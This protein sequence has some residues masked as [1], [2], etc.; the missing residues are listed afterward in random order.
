MNVTIKKLQPTKKE[1]SDFFQFKLDLYKNNRYN[2]PDL[3]ADEALTLNPKKNPAYEF[4][5]SQCFMAYHGDR[6]VGRICAII[7]YKAN[8]TWGKDYGR[9]G[10]YDFIEDQEVA[11]ELMQAAETWVAERGMVGIEGPFGFTD[12]DKE[13]MLTDGFDKLSTMATLYNYPYYPQYMEQM[14]FEK[15]A[16]WVELYIKTEPLNERVK[17][18]ADLA[19]ERLKLHPIKFKNTRQIIKDGWGDKLFELI[20]RSY[21]PLYGVSELSTKQINFYVS[22]Y[23]PLLK[24]DLISLIADSDDNLVGFGIVLPS[25][26]VAMQKANG[27]MFPFGWFY[28]LRTLFAKHSKV[29]DFMLIGVEPALQ[30]KGVNAL[31]MREIDKGLHKLKCEH[32]ES[33]PELLNN[34]KVQSMW[35]EMEHLVHKRR[36]SF[37]RIIAK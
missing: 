16:E 15:C 28:L 14:G 21:A 26:S 23:V 6:P 1:L 33:N 20:N 2:V 31:V 8:K 36:A 34:I 22:M 12:M 29:C 18:I 13:G 10:F 19:E 25:F 5:E 17:K 37:S 32:C 30:N 27:R 24:L 3:I 4:C 11:R 7:N 35:S 9:F